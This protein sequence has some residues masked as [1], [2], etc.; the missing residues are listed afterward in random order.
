M[1][2]DAPPPRAEMLNAARVAVAR[3]L[4]RPPG[5]LNNRTKAIAVRVANLMASGLDMLDALA[6]VAE[7][8]AA[9]VDQRLAA[10]RLM[11]GAL[12]C[13]VVRPEGPGG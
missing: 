4:G 2:T 5:S 8:K 6:V 10:L 13:R 12:A 3:R 11:F 1:S 9:P 7:D